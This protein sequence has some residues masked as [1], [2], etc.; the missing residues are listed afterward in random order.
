MINLTI[1][2][3][4]VQQN[5]KSNMCSIELTSILKK[6]PHIQQK[7]CNPKHFFCSPEVPVSTRKVRRK[8]YTSCRDGGQLAEGVVGPRHRRRGHAAGRTDAARRRGQ[9]RRYYAKQQATAG[10]A[11]EPAQ[12]PD[13]REPRRPAQAAQC[14]RHQARADR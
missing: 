11:P 5:Y 6:L 10:R 14:Q 4:A 2:S 12:G 9:A 13:A 3:S 8:A 7:K 1:L